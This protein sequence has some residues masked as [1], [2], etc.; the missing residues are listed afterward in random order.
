[1]KQMSPP[2]GGPYNPHLRRLDR[3][4]YDFSAARARVVPAV[5]TPIGRLAVVDLGPPP[6]DG[7]DETYR[8][9]LWFETSYIVAVNT[10]ASSPER[11]SV[12]ILSNNSDRRALSTEHK[13]LMY[14]LKKH[15]YWDPPVR[16]KLRC[17]EWE[18][19][20]EFDG[21]W[22]E[23]KIIVR[24]ACPNGLFGG[25]LCVGPIGREHSDQ[26]DDNM[27]EDVCG[28]AFGTMDPVYPDE[29]RWPHQPG[30][31]Y[32]TACIMTSYLQLGQADLTE[33]RDLIRES[34]CVVDPRVEKVRL[35][36]D[37]RGFPEDSTCQEKAGEKE[38]AQ[39]G[40]QP[41]SPS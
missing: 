26:L 24:F 18:E 1:M 40:T 13:K 22:D 23:E 36:D 32:D 34:R 6:E 10:E 7:E 35:S 5:V 41:R 20:G 14:W 15:D 33:A 30:P 12:W 37:R 17:K 4:L 25:E 16:G 19:D 29:T 31:Y 11:G 3:S 38:C 28:S 27:N 9:E 21:H 39:E 8:E 2:D